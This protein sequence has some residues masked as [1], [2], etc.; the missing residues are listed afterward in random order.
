VPV[1]TTTDDHHQVPDQIYQLPVTANMEYGFYANSMPNALK[2]DP[3]F[4][5][6]NSHSD[7]RGVGFYL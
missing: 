1:L 5:H 6:Y 2:D 7:V 3:M 4:V